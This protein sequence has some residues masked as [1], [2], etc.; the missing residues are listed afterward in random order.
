MRGWPSAV[1]GKRRCPS[2]A[3]P[4]RIRARSTA[5]TVRPGMEATFVEAGH[6]L[7]STMIGL[8][9]NGP[10]GPRRITFTGD[11][12]RPGVPILR[13][14]A[15]LPE[16]DLVISESTYGGHTHEPVEETAE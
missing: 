2:A 8:R 7:G 11:L 1:L 3:P 9:V 15:A 10:A 12:G 13:D 14:P 4:A 16:A 6:L 5:V